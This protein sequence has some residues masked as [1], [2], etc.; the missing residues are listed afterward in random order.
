MFFFQVF[1]F[2]AVSPCP[3]RNAIEHKTEWRRSYVQGW[4]GLLAGRMRK[5]GKKGRKRKK[6]EKGRKGK[7]GWVYVKGNRHTGVTT[8]KNLKF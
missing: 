8:N 6:G 7:G 4:R 1:Q 2:F 5:K 3:R